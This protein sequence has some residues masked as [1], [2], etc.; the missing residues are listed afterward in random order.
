MV[1]DSTLQNLLSK[2]AVLEQQ[3][4]LQ[5]FAIKSI[6]NTTNDIIKYEKIPDGAV[7]PPVAYAGK[8]KRITRKRK[9]MKR[10]K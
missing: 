3:Q 2:V 10:R 9:T 8:R 7:R 6:Q 4:M 5:K 1:D